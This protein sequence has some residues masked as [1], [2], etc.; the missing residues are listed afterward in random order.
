MKPFAT[1]RVA[2]SSGGIEYELHLPGDDSSGPLRDARPHLVSDANLA[3]L[4]A[5]SA[6][7]LRSTSS[8][9]FPLDAKTTGDR[10]YNALI[11]R[12]LREV[13]RDIRVPL[14]V[15]VPRFGLPFELFYADQFWGLRYALGKQIRMDLPSRRP[16]VTRSSTPLRALIISS[17]PRGDLKSVD[18]EA[19]GILE[20]LTRA[21]VEVQHRGGPQAN[22]EEVRKKLAESFDIIHYCG[23][24]DRGGM[25]SSAAS[26][27][28]LANDQV[29]SEDEI[30]TK[31]DGRPFVF[32]NGC[33]SARSSLTAGRRTWEEDISS[34]AYG[35]IRRGARAV[36]A[37]VSEIG[38][39]HAADLAVDF[40][41]RALAGECLG[42]PLCDM[43]QRAQGMERP[44]SVGQQR[45]RCERQL[46]FGTQPK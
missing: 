18:A 26:G 31:L 42:R 46:G 40:F 5:L 1:L 25:G 24:I 44:S 30:R 35:F 29:L 16:E 33:L 14:L 7:L 36:I 8:E 34:V 38:D 32:L 21:G 22:L 27:L 39:G 45:V 23:H 13:L 20:S 43:R 2:Y 3:E 12:E 37:T 19:R 11:P 6:Q 17:N 28:L 41:V 15:S 4:Q 10:L 9:S